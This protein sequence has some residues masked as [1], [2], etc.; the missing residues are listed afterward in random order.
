MIHASF[1]TFSE[2][3]PILENVQMAK[4]YLLKR[5]ATAKKIKT[6]EI[7]EE[8]KQ[9]ILNDPKFK[10]VRDLTQK[11]PN[12]TPL[13]TKFAFDQGAEM[14]E[15]Q[16]IVD[17]MTQY[18]NNLAKDLEM[19]VIDYG[20]IEPTEDDQRPGYEVLGDDLRNIPRKV[21]LRK[22]YNR[23]VPEMK[24][25]FAKATPKQIEKLEEIS[26]QLDQMPD[27]PAEPGGKDRNAW[28]EFTQ[29][30]KKYTDTRTYPEYRDRE[31]A[32]GD[33]IKDADLFIEKWQESD[34]ELVMKLKTMGAQVGWLY[35]K[36]GYIAISTR[37][38]EALRAV[39]G[40]TNWCIRNDSTFWSYGEGRVQLVIM[41]KNIPTSDRN[42]LL[43]ITVNKNESIHTDADRPNGRIRSN[44]GST[45]SNLS[46]LL[47]GMRLPSALADA[48]LN[49]FPIEA[50]IKLAMEQF[51]RHQKDLTP[52]KIIGSMIN[53]N[54]GFLQ[55]KLPE[56]EW[57]KIAGIVSEIIK[58]TEK[59][60]TSE[61]L[62]F[63]KQNGI[64]SRSGLAVFDRVVGDDYTPEDV[65]EMKA[66]SMEGFETME[67]II[68]ENKR[69]A[70]KTKP[71]EIER[72]KT[73][74]DNKDSILDKLSK[75]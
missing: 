55:N 62:K 33:I 6:S 60:K 17:L 61:F 19:P 18:K 50:D 15:L 42:S 54:R 71:E 68:E 23:L 36:D 67:Y 75:M 29:N 41:N 52:E 14:E 39:A 45:Y 58:G 9:K 63:F 2:A 74:V 47:K 1:K 43:G 28:D 21:K 22:L 13:F 44:S 66:S 73:C 25:Q 48:V 59:L 11:F 37:T 3:S 49:E 57:E 32:F 38:P 64:L 8:T 26:N 31:L 16:E 72:M 40:D 24:I 7:P 70:M 12:Y 30:M 53:I 46:D 65:E 34:D 4:D 10:Q 51:F 27:K 69:K 5:Y 20:K 56:S 35:Q